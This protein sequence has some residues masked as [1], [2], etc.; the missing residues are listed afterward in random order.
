MN[1][2]TFVKNN[3]ARLGLA[4]YKAGVS[5]T[6]MKEAF[7]K[8]KGTVDTSEKQLSKRFSAADNKHFQRGVKTVKEAI[9]KDLKT[10]NAD[11]YKNM[12]D[13]WDKLVNNKPNLPTKSEAIRSRKLRE[14][15]LQERAKP[16]IEDEGRKRREALMAERTR[17]QREEE[18]QEQY[19]KV[20]TMK[21]KKK[22][23]QKKG[24][25]LIEIADNKLTISS[26]KLVGFL[27]E[28]IE[29]Y[30]RHQG[31]RLTNLSKSNMTR[32]HGIIERHNIPLKDLKQ[33]YNDRITYYNE[34][35]Q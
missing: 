32:L 26:F 4:N 2:F 8:S 3:W 19:K 9:E 13:M 31:K 16:Q 33:F 11:M 5:S 14:T 35:K 22:P 24:R 29:L 1:Y 34:K 15:Q 18:G 10:G 27:R 25:A 21:H 6:K 20:I 12:D 7:K 17:Q 28:A 23:R 30:Y